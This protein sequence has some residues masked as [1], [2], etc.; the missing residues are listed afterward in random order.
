MSPAREFRFRVSTAKELMA[1]YRGKRDKFSLSAFEESRI[2]YLNLLNQREV[3][4]KQ[5]AKQFW[6]IDGDANTRYFHSM[7]EEL[8]SQYSIRSSVRTESGMRSSLL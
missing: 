7:C 3:L 8:V 5:W 1:R 6:L 4:W 2:Q